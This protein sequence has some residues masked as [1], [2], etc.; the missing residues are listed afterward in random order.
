M[1]KSRKPAR[2]RHENSNENSNENSVYRLHADVRQPGGLPDFDLGLIEWV[3]QV[4]QR[5]STSYFLVGDIFTLSP[6]NRKRMEGLLGV[7]SEHAPSVHGADKRGDRHAMW[8]RAC[9]SLYELCAA[10]E[11]PVS[12]AEAFVDLMSRRKDT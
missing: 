12:I 11:R 2:E 5:A 4:R 3:A 6:G 10:T 1:A 9:A 7:M 8:L